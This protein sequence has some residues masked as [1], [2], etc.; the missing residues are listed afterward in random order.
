MGKPCYAAIPTGARA[1]DA[2]H[3]S[4]YTGL[5]V[6]NNLFLLFGSNDGLAKAA[7]QA[8][9]AKAKITLQGTLLTRRGTTLGA[10]ARVVSARFWA[11]EYANAAEVVAPPPRPSVAMKDLAFRIRNRC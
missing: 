3:A 8:Q 1:K 2:I 10:A 11:P 7:K 4:P 5:L 6:P 9:E